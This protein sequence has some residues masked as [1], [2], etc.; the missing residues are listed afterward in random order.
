MDL[1]ADMPFL[2][3]FMVFLGVFSCCCPQAGVLGQAAQAVGDAFVAKG[4]CLL[5]VAGERHGG[6][7][8][9]EAG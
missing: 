2:L 9:A 3:G 7:S 8:W 5:C 4:K 6:P 1:D